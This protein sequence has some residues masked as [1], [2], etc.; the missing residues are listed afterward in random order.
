MTPKDKELIENN[1]GVIRKVVLRFVPYSEIE[2]SWQFAV[3]CCKVCEKIEMWNPERGNITTFISIVAYNAILQEIREQS[4]KSLPLIP[5]D[6]I[7]DV[8]ILT[9]NNRLRLSAPYEDILKKSDLPLEVIEIFQRQ[10]KGETVKSIS[11]DLGI[12]RQ[13]YYKRIRPIKTILKKHL[14]SEQD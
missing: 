1:I 10:V 8:P 13:S 7:E 11:K 14:I 2:D 5:L 6:D 4:R 9:T 3:A 12:S